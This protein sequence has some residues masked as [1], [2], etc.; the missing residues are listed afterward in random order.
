MSKKTQLFKNLGS[1]VPQFGISSQIVNMK[2]MW[3]WLKRCNQNAAVIITLNIFKLKKIADTS[4]SDLITKS[5]LVIKSTKLITSRVEQQ[6]ALTNKNSWSICTAQ[7]KYSNSMV[8]K[9]TLRSICFTLKTLN[10]LSILC[11]NGFPRSSKCS[12]Q[13]APNCETQ[14]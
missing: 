4:I 10:S 3:Y 5:N 14:D 9:I 7:L 13:A 11:N 1:C 12:R 6:S 8:K 2:G